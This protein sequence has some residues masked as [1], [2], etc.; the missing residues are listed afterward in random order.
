MVDKGAIERLE[1]VVATPFVRITYTE[2]I[3]ILQKSIAD[4]RKF[5][6]AVEWGI[7]LATEHERHIAEDIYKQPV[8][9]YNYP[10]E[11]KS[12]YMKLNPDGKTVAAMDMLVPKIGELIGGSQREDNYD[13]LEARIKVGALCCAVLRCAALCCAVLRCAALCCAVLRCA[14]LCCLFPTCVVVVNVPSYACAESST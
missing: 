7:D 1:Q 5:E 9:V 4:G 2:A 14:A 10:K 3:E 6:H 12:F 8:I 13:I 11:I